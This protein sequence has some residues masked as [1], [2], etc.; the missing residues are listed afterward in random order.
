MEKQ[1]VYNGIHY[2]LHGDYYFPDLEY[3]T[4]YYKIGRWG[5]MRLEY[6]KKNC[7][8]RLPLKYNMDNPAKPCRT[9]D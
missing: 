8:T 2:T 7:Q 6:L 9:R 5:R 3:R 4:T 1:I